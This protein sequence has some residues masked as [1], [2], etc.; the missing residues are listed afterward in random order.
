M[1]QRRGPGSI[2]RMAEVTWTDVPASGLGDSSALLLPTTAR[3]R[4]VPV[5]N[6]NGTPGS[7]S[8]RLADSVQALN[9]SANISAQVG[10]TGTWS[11]A[12]IPIATLV[13]PVNDVP[14]IAGA[15]ST[16]SYTENAAAGRA[17]TGRQSG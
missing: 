1:L 9:T 2:P 10:G 14:T 16:Q 17:G 5:A 12:A 4:F 15:G 7:L 13:S 11:A 3:L 8:V 6:Y